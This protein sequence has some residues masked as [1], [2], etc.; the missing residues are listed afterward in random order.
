MTSLS[1]TCRRTLSRARNLMTTS[2]LVSLFLAASL[3]VFAFRLA[4]A[5]GSRETFATLW[6][7]SVS[8]VLLL[9][10][11]IKVLFV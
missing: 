5:E 1:I 4:D 8:L 11:W 9:N 3:A 7:T 6:T 2:F 10:V